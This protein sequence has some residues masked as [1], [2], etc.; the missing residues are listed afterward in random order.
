MHH[1]VDPPEL[2]GDG[3][4]PRG[5]GGV[6]EEVDRVAV[7]SAARRRYLLSQRLEPLD[8]GVGHDDG[9]AGS[10]QLPHHSAA[11]SAAR[12]RHDDNSAAQR[13]TQDRIPFVDAITSE[14]LRRSAS[15][16][17][18]NG[19]SSGST[20]LTSSF[21]GPSRGSAAAPLVAW[22]H[23]DIGFGAT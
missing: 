13:L 3:R 1:T 6:V 22:A 11:R 14:S 9:R 18:F 23:T 4:R 12:A 17:T 8:R 15:K 16:N 19:N 2:L 5:G 10:S 21:G 20:R 7:R